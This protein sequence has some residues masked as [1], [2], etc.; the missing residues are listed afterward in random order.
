M[1]A[2]TKHNVELTISALLNGIY[3]RSHDSLSYVPVLANEVV[4][5]QGQ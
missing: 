5:S 2:S 1:Q 4:G 3:Q